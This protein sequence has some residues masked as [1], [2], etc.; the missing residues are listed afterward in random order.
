MSGCA[1]QAEERET[2]ATQEVS[3][4][5]TPV[6]SEGEVVAPGETI[7]S[8]VTVGPSTPG[9]AVEPTY[10]VSEGT[11]AAQPEATTEP[12]AAATAAPP[13]QPP[14]SSGEQ[15]Y[16]EHT[17]RAGETLSSIARR[18]GTPL[19]EI[20]EANDD[21]TNPSLIRVGQVLKIPTTGGSSGSPSSGSTSGS[22]SG[23]TTG[24]R[25]KHTVKR[26]EWVWQIARNYGV[27]PY[28]ILSANGLSV[29]SGRVI[30]PGTVLCIP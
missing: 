15:G 7:V 19:L 11:P 12:G 3:T 14:T 16:V 27:S 26:G 30:L 6:S 4:E 5:G 17:V 13:T 24:C 20:V 9:S 2:E 1:R 23:S 18:Y 10:E 25:V 29:A 21:V 22:S 8:A 28:D